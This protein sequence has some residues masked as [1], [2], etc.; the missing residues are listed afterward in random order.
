MTALL[1][2]LLVT[3]RPSYTF[4]WTL[5]AFIALLAMHL[6]YWIFTHPVNKFWMRDRK[7]E[8]FSGGFFGFDPMKR[9]APTE[10]GEAGWT[11]I[12]NR[13]EYSHVVRAAFAAISLV[14]LVI[15]VAMGGH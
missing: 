12:R 10:S 9:S 13:W 1:I 2:L 6:A 14:S 15:A 8:G 3:P 4:R 5:I 7:L 11:R